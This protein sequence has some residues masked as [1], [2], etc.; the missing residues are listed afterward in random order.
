[1]SIRKKQQDDVKDDFKDNDFEGFA[2]PTN[3]YPCSEHP[4]AKEE[5]KPRPKIQALV[6]EGANGS[7]FVAG[8]IRPVA[9]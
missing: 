5:A 3:F 8:T 6:V 1:M 9:P 4:L 7:K 2:Q